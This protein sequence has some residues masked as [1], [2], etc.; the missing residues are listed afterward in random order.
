[1]TFAATIAA[2]PTTGVPS[3]V[4]PLSDVNFNG[5]FYAYAV[6]SGMGTFATATQV[7]TATPGIALSATAGRR[8]T[9]VKFTS[10]VKTCTGP[11]ASCPTTTYASAATL[12][13]V[14]N[15]LGGGT[16]FATLISSTA[17]QNAVTGALTI[18]APTGVSTVTPS[19]TSTQVGDA[20]RTA[21]VAVTAFTTAVIAM[22]M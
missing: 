5:A 3:L 2:F 22:I 1:M 7:F 17:T 12:A 19:T 16:T 10:T 11:V 8:G 14:Q 20:G 13:T 6:A 9:A 15:T 18:A 4:A 21:F